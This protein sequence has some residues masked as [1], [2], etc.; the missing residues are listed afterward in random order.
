M[1]ALQAKQQQQLRVGSA[2]SLGCR[3]GTGA[4][5]S[6][7]FGS[8]HRRYLGA[9]GPAGAMA[10][11]EQRWGGRAGAPCPLPQAEPG[12]GLRGRGAPGGRFL[13]SGR[14]RRGR[15][16]GAGRGAAG[17][18]GLRDWR[19]AAEAAR[20][21][22]EPPGRRAGGH[23]PFRPLLLR[24]PRLPPGAARARPRSRLRGPAGPR[25]AAGS[26]REKPLRSVAGRAREGILPLRC[27]GEAHLECCAQCW[28]PQDEMGK[29]L[30]ERALRRIC[31]QRIC[32][33]SVSP[34]RR[35]CGAGP[36]NIHQQGN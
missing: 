16:G 36:G 23:I 13:P 22:P 5:R 2:R 33:W 19:G 6:P 8:F 29:E 27:P 31:S 26:S 35:H 12:A 20:E 1:S 28:A 17:T 18:P 34:M 9:G 30:P 14:A 4:P 25:R 15:A 10:A 3:D 32:G 21:I 7:A 11:S 24:R